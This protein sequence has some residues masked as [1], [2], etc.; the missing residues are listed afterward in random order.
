MPR[1]DG[2]HNHVSEER[3]SGI[4]PAGLRVFQPVAG[5]PATRADCPEARPCVFVACRMHLWREDGPDR[6]GRRYEGRHPATTLRAAWL[7]EPLPPSCALDVADAIREHGQPPRM[8]VI[9]ALLGLRPSQARELLARALA[10]LRA[11]GSL[12]E[13]DGP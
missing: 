11:A 12:E 4:R 3:L 5:V 10:K 6:A 2:Q 1:A 9:A 13:I 7:R 8:E